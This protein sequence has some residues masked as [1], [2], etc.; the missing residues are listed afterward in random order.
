MNYRTTKPI[1][2]NVLF[3]VSR[4]KWL[5]RGCG[6][7]HSRDNAEIEISRFLQACKAAERIV[8]YEGAL[9]NQTTGGL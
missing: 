2:L 5:Q 6:E 7:K 4:Q 9:R 1:D 8:R 3:E